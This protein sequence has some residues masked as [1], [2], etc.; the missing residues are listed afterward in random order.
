MGVG[1]RGLEIWSCICEK[2][3]TQ[4]ASGLAKSYN[5]QILGKTTF[6]H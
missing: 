4:W 2:Q 6:I 1:E 5:N 3:I